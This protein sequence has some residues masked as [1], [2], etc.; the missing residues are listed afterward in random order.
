MAQETVT[1]VLPWAQLAAALAIAAGC[2]VP[3]VGAT[4]WFVLS[5]SFV[6][7]AELG[8][9]ERARTDWQRAHEGEHQDIKLTLVRIEGAL[10]HVPSA[11][12]VSA[13][14][15][16]VARLGAVAQGLDGKL[17]RFQ[18]VLDVLLTAHVR[19]A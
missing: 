1:L 8:R 19:E 6:T 4:I 7:R 16:D 15:A 3:A 2:V 9:L 12:D 11:A 18:A 13:L 5:K 17:D 14:R 10:L